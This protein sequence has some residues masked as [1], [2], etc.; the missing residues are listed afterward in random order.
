MTTPKIEKIRLEPDV[1]EKMG[2]KGLALIVIQSAFIFA[3]LNDFENTNI[4]D[5]AKPEA[6]FTTKGWKGSENG[7]GGAYWQMDEDGDAFKEL[8]EQVK[9]ARNSMG[10]LEYDKAVTDLINSYYAIP[11]LKGRK[12]KE[13]DVELLKGLKL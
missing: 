2:R 9:A 4:K 12:G 8:Y 6:L 1:L 13:I 5:M 11:S 3:K 7:V 10:K